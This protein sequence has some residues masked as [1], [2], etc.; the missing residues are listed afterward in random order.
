MLPDKDP[1]EIVTV[2]F[3]FSAETTELAAPVITCTRTG[4][5]TDDHPEFL[6][7]GSAQISGPTVKQRVVGGVAG[8]DYNI[9]CQVDFPDGRRYVLADTLQVRSA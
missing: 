7:S 4:G 1:R 6:L 2:T 9:Q 8:A 5:V 3:D